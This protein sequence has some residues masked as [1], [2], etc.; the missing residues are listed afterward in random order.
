M[1][2]GKQLPL[3]IGKTVLSAYQQYAASPLDYVQLGFSDG[4]K[5]LVMPGYPAGLAVEITEPRLP[6]N[7]P[8]LDWIL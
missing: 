7:C 8:S 2:F 1:I 3:A 5:L 6:N 4:T